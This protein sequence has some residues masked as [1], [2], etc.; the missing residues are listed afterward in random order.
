MSIRMYCTFF[1]FCECSGVNI[2]R[3]IYANVGPQIRQ[4]MQMRYKHGDEY[5]E[6]NSKALLLLFAGGLDVY[7]D[8]HISG[9]SKCRKVEALTGGVLVYTR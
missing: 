9:E 3:G 8:T 1:F 6:L 2:G 7:Q 4:L 5:G